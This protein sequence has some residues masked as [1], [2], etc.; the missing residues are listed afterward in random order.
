MEV[1]T[2]IDKIS[3]HFIN[4]LS[5]Q[6]DS[7]FMFFDEYPDEFGEADELFALIDFLESKG[8]VSKIMNN[9]TFAGVT[10]THVSR[11]K[12]EFRKI[13]FLSYVK[14]NW[15]AILALI[16]SIAAFIRSFF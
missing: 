11:H 16:I 15:I 1:Y 7:T 6:P 10:L 9:G 12:S 4:F 3:K 13:N 5:N 8:F 2:V 14:N